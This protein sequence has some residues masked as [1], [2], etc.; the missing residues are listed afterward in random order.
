MKTK[1]IRL[2]NGAWIDPLT[3]KCVSAA[4]RTEPEISALMGGCVHPARV[5]IQYN[6]SS[7]QILAC[8]DLAQ[9]QKL[10][11]ELAAQF[12]EVRGARCGMTK[13]RILITVSGGVVQE[14]QCDQEAEVFVFDWDNVNN[15]DT[16]PPHER[17]AEDFRLA[18]Y[19]AEAFEDHLAACLEE[20]RRIDEDRRKFEAEIGGGQ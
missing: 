2:H 14:V 19:A 12:N 20:V 1:L 18:P 9:A 5:I 15:A 3:V 17:T 8:N 13:P 16:T 10:A 11:D 7:Y 6:E 4:P